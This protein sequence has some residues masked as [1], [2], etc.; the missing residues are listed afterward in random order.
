[1]STRRLT[2]VVLS[3]SDL[4]IEVA[5]RLRVEH[6]VDRATLVTAPSTRR[7]LS[8][9]EKVQYVHRTEGWRGLAATALRKVSRLL[10]STVNESEGTHDL[11]LHP[12]IE[13]LRFVDFESIEC[14][15]AIQSR[16]PDLGVIAGTYILSEKVFEIPR[17]GSINLHSGKAPEYRGAAPAFWELYNGEHTVGITIH[18]VTA[19]LDAGAILRQEIF[20]VDP[21][22]EGDPIDYI[23]R[24]RRTV[25]RPNGVRMLV[26]AVASIATNGT[27]HGKA[28]DP[29]RVTTYRT[30]DYAA[31]RELRRRVQARRR[32]RQS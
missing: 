22:P 28:Q 8:M 26:E 27:V 18:R 30:P 32:E 7:P 5:N 3:C 1:M 10:P 4:G 25:L 21:A 6:F 31:V 16:S 23:D 14:R 15:T 29:S 12:D 11:V 9:R 2:V 19:A 20:P 13:H 17:L 24:Y